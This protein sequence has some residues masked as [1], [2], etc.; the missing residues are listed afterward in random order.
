M[1]IRL[2][3]LVWDIA[4]PT[5][6]QKLI[7]LKLAD[8]ASDQGG[9]IFPAVNTIAAHVGCDERTVQRVLKSFRDAGVLHLVKDGGNGPKATNQWQLDV[10]AL[11]ALSSG[12][13]WLVGGASGIEMEGD[14]VIKGDILS[15]KGGILPPSMG[16]IPSGKG[17]I[18]SD[19]GGS[20]ATRLFTNLQ[21]SSSKSAGAPATLRAA[22]PSLEVKAGDMSWEPW[23][24]AI[25]ASIGPDARRSAEQQGAIRVEGRWP[26]PGVPMPAINV[27][28]DPTGGD[29]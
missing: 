21:D 4:F 22:R 9:S 12:K 6:S 18:L 17:G 23:L 10:P 25:E 15:D 20:G 14:V 24:A 16:G 8:Y 26:R 1:S 13:A 11:N 2:M 19:K 3:S 5:H 7:A 27:V 28:R 29:A